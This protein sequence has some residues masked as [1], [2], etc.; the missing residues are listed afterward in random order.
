VFEEGTANSQIPAIQY[1]LELA[2]LPNMEKQEEGTA[3]LEHHFIFTIKCVEWHTK[4]K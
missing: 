1:L 2:T 4:I 3:I